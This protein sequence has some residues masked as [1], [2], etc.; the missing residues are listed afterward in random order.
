MY[1][2]FTVLLNI[3]WYFWLDYLPRWTMALSHVWR[4]L[5]RQLV[6][7]PTGAYG[8]LC[9]QTRDV[10]AQL[11]LR[12]RGCRAGKHHRSRVEAARR[13]TSST[14]GDSARSGAIPVIVGNRRASWRNRCA[15]EMIVF[16]RSSLSVVVALNI[17]HQLSSVCWMR[18]QCA[19]R[20]PVR[21]LIQT[22]QQCTPTLRSEQVPPPSLYVLNA[23]AIT[24]PSAI[25]HLTADLIG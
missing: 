11:G 14:A 24:K 10:I 1:W 8:T 25:E 13:M 17:T 7:Q 9:Q 2:P 5:T 6:N 4:T 16:L 3:N 22:N 21:I 18:G 12:R 23:A 19:V 20:P 15:N